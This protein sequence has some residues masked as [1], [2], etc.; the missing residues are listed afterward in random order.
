M[1]KIDNQW[2][3]IEE[4]VITADVEIKK[5]SSEQDPSDSNL[6]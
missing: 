2:L 5:L 1:Q 3:I 6:K 4:K